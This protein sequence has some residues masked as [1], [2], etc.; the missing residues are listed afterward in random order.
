MATAKK[1]GVIKIPNWCENELVVKGEVKELVRF[2]NF[3]KTQKSKIDENKFIPYPEHFKELDDVHREW[4]K[5]ADRYADAITKTK[6]GWY[7][8]DLLTE[9]Q[10]KSFTDLHGEQPKDGYNQGGYE[11]CCNNWGTKW[12]LCNAEGF[13]NKEKK[14]IFYNFDT[15]WSPPEPLVRKMAEMFPELEFTLKFWESGMGFRGTTKYK[16]EEPQIV[17]KKRG[18]IE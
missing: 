9:T 15:A 7:C 11:W 17:K 8:G 16:A 6:R 12:G 1:R 3:A 4:L 14:R 13:I 5:K 2:S 18:F 10:R